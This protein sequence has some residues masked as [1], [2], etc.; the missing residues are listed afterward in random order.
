MR[1]AGRAAYLRSLCSLTAARSLLAAGAAA[2]AM[3][4]AGC[5][6]SPMSPMPEPREGRSGLQLSGM[7][8]GRQ[9]AVSDGLPRLLIG[10][11]SVRHG[12]PAE[13]CFASRNIDGAL[14]VIG[15]ANPEAIAANGRMDA[16]RARCTTT[17]GCGEVSDHALVFV[18]VDEETRQATGG[19]VSISDLAAGS[20][21]VG[22]LRL[23]VG[24][25][26]LTGSFDVVPRPEPV[27]HRAAATSG[28]LH[29]SRG[30]NG[31]A[32]GGRSPTPPGGPPGR[33]RPRGR[34]RPG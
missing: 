19:S 29:E 32:T 34:P 3:L 11:C 15:I 25:E 21:Y 33:G 6:A 2:L 24:G 5:G 31:Q 13:V 22:E 4:L 10:E 7:F 18:R 9:I 16:A 17:P 20:R 30:R 14:V 8:A 26:R 12:I 28:R 27:A 23:D 1:S